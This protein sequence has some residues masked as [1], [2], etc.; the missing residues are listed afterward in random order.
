MAVADYEPL[1][2]GPWCNAGV[3]VLDAGEEV[4]VGQQTFRGL[5]FLIGDGKS[6][7]ERCFI[8][9]EPGRKSVTVPIGR[10]ATHVIF[11]HRQLES[12]VGTPSFAGSMPVGWTDYEGAGSLIAE[13]LFRF[14][15][16]P[17]IRAPIRE[18]FEILPLPGAWGRKAY[19]AVPDQKH[20]LHPRYEGRWEMA[21]ARQTE[22]HQGWPS[23]YYLW[24]WQN[25]GELAC[26]G[27]R[28]SAA[29]RKACARADQGDRRHLHGRV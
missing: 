23:G 25:Y 28:A 20:G 14:R 1:D 9:L 27:P 29:A 16:A 24:A 15:E 5:P 11:A 22:A 6:A 19:G 3:E 8:L 13:Y 10:R 21:G 12:Q 17:D 18:R 2:I 26:S 4:P 7:G